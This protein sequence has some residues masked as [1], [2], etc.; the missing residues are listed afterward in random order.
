MSTSAI[1]RSLPNDP[2]EA[3]QVVS[4]LLDIPGVVEVLLPLPI[5]DLPDARATEE[6][7]ASLDLDGFRIVLDQRIK[8]DA[9]ALNVAAEAACE[10]TLLILEIPAILEASAPISIAN[11]ELDLL[12]IPVFEFS[13][14]AGWDNICDYTH[15]AIARSRP[16]VYT[17][18]KQLFLELRGYDE[19]SA[20][21]HTLGLD[22]TERHLRLG[23][24]IHESRTVIGW[25]KNSEVSAQLVEYDNETPSLQSLVD[26]DKSIFRNLI[27]WTVKPEARPPLITVAVATKDRG[28]LLLE[29]LHSIQIQSFRDYEVIIVDDGSYDADIV[30][31]VVEQLADDRFKLIQLDHSKGVAHARNTAAR[32]STCRYTAVHDDDDLML[33]HRLA[34]GLNGI[35]AESD[36]SY[37]GWINFHDTT[38]EL[39]AFVTKESFSHEMLADSGA[40][41]G[42]STWT[43]PTKLLRDFKYDERLT[44]SVDHELATRLLNAG[45]RWKHVGEFMYLRRVH[46][47]QITGK[48][49]SNQKAGHTLS[50][51]RSR[52][53]ANQNGLDLLAEGGKNLKWPQ[54]MSGD[55]LFK[56]Y[57]GYLPDHLVK[58]NLRLDGNSIS[59]SIAAD[60]PSQVTDLVVE[61][62]AV[63]DSPVVE[64][65][66]IEDVSLRQLASLRKRGLLKYSIE[67]EKRE[68]TEYQKTMI[69]SDEFLD[70]KF[71]SRCEAFIALR[72]L[73]MKKAHP[74]AVLQIHRL[75]AQQ[76]QEVGS[77]LQKDARLVSAKKL[78]VAGQEGRSSRFLL[79][80][81]VSKDSLKP[82][83]SGISQAMLE[84]PF[85]IDDRPSIE[86]A[87]ERFNDSLSATYEESTEV[88]E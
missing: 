48:D 10:D 51:I 71:I 79:L 9:Q 88:V 30:K 21:S 1:L 46:T 47:H 75:S 32:A 66:F 15:L 44:A 2:N 8:N 31:T 26:S 33:P 39:R 13:E 28:D 59:L 74:D 7:A 16:V 72:I 73:T 69:P 68:D 81:T 50:L 57:G 56:K 76:Y 63:N 86:I 42:H 37:G 29:C 64:S 3:N 87:V 77:F 12:T 61:R 27:D 40:A 6:T 14:Y 41:P 54:G 43:V 17:M 11:P 20:Y 80:A 45:V 55:N 60:L 38:G 85:F 70:T 82:T 84:A 4:A 22:L 24:S 83:N 78:L 36:A 19:R 49:S 52:F 58:R 5:N 65:G 34:S 62:N 53:L 35:T 18:A 23:G 25:S 67:P